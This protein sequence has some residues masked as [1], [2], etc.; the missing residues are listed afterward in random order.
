MYNDPL[1][2]PLADF[3]IT[4]DEEK[5]ID[6]ALSLDDSWTLDQVAMAPVRLVLKGLRD[7]IKEFHLKRQGGLCCYCR[8]NLNGGGVFTIDREHIVPKSHVKALTYVMTNL[9]VACKRCNMEIKK[10]KVSLFYSPKT[11]KDTHLSEGSYKIIHPN[12]E[13]YENFIVRTQHQHGTAVLVKYMQLNEDPKTKFTFDFFKLKELEINS[14]DAAQGIIP[15]SL[16]QGLL[17]DALK[18]EVEKQ[19]EFAE[20]ILKILM[21]SAPKGISQQLEVDRNKKDISNPEMISD[22]DISGFLK[23]YLIKSERKKLS[24]EGQVVLALPFLGAQDD[25]T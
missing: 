16:T 8:S 20:K 24:I 23:K 5:A 2:P 18:A 22:F 7:R 1:H 12:F 21:G 25:E 15:A 11:I 14:F 9:S 6:Y 17:L 19:P 4:E 3:K 13:K 10:D